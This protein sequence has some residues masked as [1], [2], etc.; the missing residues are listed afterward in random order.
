IIVDVDEIGDNALKQLS[1]T[2]GIQQN[3]LSQKYKIHVIIKGS[4][5][6]IKEQTNLDNFEFSSDTWVYIDVRDIEPT[7]SGLSQ[8]IQ[9]IDSLKCKTKVTHLTFSKF[10]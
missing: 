9:Y 3:L 8:A 7:I 1:Q 5:R 10:I 4:E 6:K 2:M